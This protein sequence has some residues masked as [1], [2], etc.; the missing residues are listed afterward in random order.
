MAQDAGMSTIEPTPVTPEHITDHITS[1][2]ED[3]DVVTIPDWTFFS[4]DPE[5]HWPN[6]ATLGTADDAYDR[7]SDLSR[8]GVFRL[9]IGVGRATFDAIAAADPSPD[10]TALD[11]LMPH[12]VYAAQRWVCILNP[13]Q[14]TFERVVKPLLAE[15]HEI[16]ARRNRKPRR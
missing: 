7:F 14:G 3:V 2:F 15:A 13:S 16:V 1:T 10:F 12:P 9:N 8:S 5:K 6:F 11:T 4:R